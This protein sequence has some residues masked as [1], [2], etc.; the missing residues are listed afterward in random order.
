MES[1][2]DLNADIGGYL[3]KD[4]LWWYFSARDQ[5]IKSL[6][7]N[8]PVKAFET[9]LRNLTGKGTYALDTEQQDHR[10]RPGRPQAS[11]QSHGHVRGRRR[12]W[13][14]TNQ[15][16][17]PGVSSTGVTPIRPAG[18]ASSTTSCSSRS[19][20]GSSSTNGRTSVT[21]KTPA[22]QDIGN[23]LVRGGNRDGWFN[24]PSRNQVLG[25][26]SYFKEGMGRQP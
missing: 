15:T 12:S 23:S 7:P 24:I 19:V 1:Y 3:K 4:K 18:T 6:L 11:A 5:N 16:T 22:F 9:G 13:P 21:R 2:H 14:A 8:F 17:R 26:V 10:L 25:S 20:A